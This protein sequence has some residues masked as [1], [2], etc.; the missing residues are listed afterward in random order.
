MPVY[1]LTDADVFQTLFLY[2]DNQRD[3]QDV[4]SAFSERVEKAKNRLP[5]PPVFYNK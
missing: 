3:S 4:K 5:E 1:F 2:A